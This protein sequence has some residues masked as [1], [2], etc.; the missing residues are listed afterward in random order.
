MH[1]FRIECKVNDHRIGLDWDRDYGVFHRRGWTL[2]VNGS[3]I[4]QLTSLRKVVKA[5]VRR[6]IVAGYD[7]ERHASL[8]ESFDGEK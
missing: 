7:K 5:V 1:T 2:W 3:A 8:A 4:V 6:A